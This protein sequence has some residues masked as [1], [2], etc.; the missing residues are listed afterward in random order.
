MNRDIVV[1][2]K[3]R[4]GG[5]IGRMLAAKLGCDIV[6]ENYFPKLRIQDDSI[7]LNYGRSAI[8][9]WMEAALERGV[10]IINLPAA[11]GRA[12]NKAVCM[13]TLDAAGVKTLIS[14]T[15]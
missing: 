10:R 1:Y 13:K 2:R 4:R 14:L 6:V 9:V 7:V 15:P 8:P 12:V 3:S 11:V 5:G